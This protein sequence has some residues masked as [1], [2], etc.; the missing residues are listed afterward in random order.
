IPLLASQRRRSLCHITW[1]KHRTMAAEPFQTVKNGGAMPLATVFTAVSRFKRSKSRRRAVSNGVYGAQ[2]FQTVKIAAPC[3][4]QRC[5]RR[6][7][8]S[9]GQNRAAMPSATV[10][11]ALSRFKRA[12][13]L[14]HAVSNGD[15]GAQPFQTGKIAAPCR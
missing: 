4:Q 15:Y 13:S 7:A 3:R 11:T 6:S 8:V 12:K 10:I 2:P 9:N 14:R 5:L 1:Q